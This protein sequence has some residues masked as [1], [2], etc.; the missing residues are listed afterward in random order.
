MR[1]GI[2]ELDRK[3][4]L[5]GMTNSKMSIPQAVLGLSAF[6]LNLCLVLTYP[7]AAEQHHPTPDRRFPVALTAT[8]PTTMLTAMPQQGGVTEFRYFSLRLLRPRLM[9]RDLEAR[10]VAH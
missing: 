6:L 3:V 7:G 8:P 4:Y 2:S 5:F 10:H 9:V 1:V